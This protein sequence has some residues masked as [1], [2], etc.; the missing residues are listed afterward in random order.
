MSSNGKFSY[1]VPGMSWFR[2]YVGLVMFA[3]VVFER[4]G[5]KCAGLSASLANGSGGSWIMA[6]PRFGVVYP[7]L[8]IALFR[9][10]QSRWL[11]PGATK[12]LSVNVTVPGPPMPGWMRGR[13]F[14]LR[15]AFQR[16]QPLKAGRGRMGRP[17]KAGMVNP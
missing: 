9:S 10:V 15:P 5:R 11:K 1:R 14:C 13:Q 3:V 17:T 16:V 2:C 12:G 7:Q 6:A 8:R 4:L